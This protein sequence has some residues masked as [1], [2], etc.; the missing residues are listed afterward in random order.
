LAAGF[1]VAFAAGN[2]SNSTARAAFP[3][4]TAL[5]GAVCILALLSI[6]G[7]LPKPLINFAGWLGKVSYSTYLFHLIFL[8]LVTKLLAIGTAL[9]FT[10]YLVLTAGFCLTFYSAVE[11]P[12]LAARPAYTSRTPRVSVRSAERPGLL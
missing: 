7:S 4:T 10:A 12:I 5:F 11:R 3:Y 6:E 2:L 9:E 1:L 8:L